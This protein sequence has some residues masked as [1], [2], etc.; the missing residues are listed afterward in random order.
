MSIRTI[1]AGNANMFLSPIFRQTLA[2]VSGATIK[3]YDTDGAAGA[4]KGAGVG[5]GIYATPEDASDTLQ[6][7]DTVYP[8]NQDEYQEAYRRW[9]QTLNEYINN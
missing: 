8:Q 4:A 6:T 1:H 3:L 5:V 2:G 9:K 7:L